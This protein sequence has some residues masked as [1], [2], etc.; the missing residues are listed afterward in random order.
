MAQL[1]GQLE[2]YWEQG[3][4]GSIAFAFYDLKNKQLIFLHNGQGLTIYDV[5]DKIL[6]SGK[7]QFVK[8]GFF[9]KHSLAA[10]IWSE[11]KQKGVSYAD[12]MAWFWQKPHLKAKLIIE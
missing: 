11:T 6:W 10:N 7:L 4:E 8:R 5:D 12:W 2:A 3:W 1:Q 9:E